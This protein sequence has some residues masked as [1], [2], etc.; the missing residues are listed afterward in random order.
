MLIKNM[1]RLNN[2][3]QYKKRNKINY[4]IFDKNY[5]MKVNI[6]VDNQRSWFCKKAN[7]LIEA[8]E[9]TGHSCNFYFD[10]NKI[11]KGS[12]IS[13]FLSHEGYVAHQTRNKSKYNI[14]VHAS[15]LPKGRGMSPTT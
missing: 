2:N 3:F 13:F 10:Q 4:Y 15:D 6:V 14:V 9:K 1:N 11:K 12:D 8:I 7:N 5:R